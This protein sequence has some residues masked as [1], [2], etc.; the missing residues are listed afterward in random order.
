MKK[1]FSLTLGL[2][3]TICWANAQTVSQ[4]IEFKTGRAA[5]NFAEKKMK[6][7]PKKLYINRFNVNFQLIYIDSE[8]TREGVYHGATSST[9][10]VGFE[11]VPQAD[12]QAITDE[13]Y[14]NYITK[15]EAAGYEILTADDASGIKEFEEYTR[16][17]GGKMSEVQKLGYGTITPT[18]FDYYVKRLGKDG[19]EKGIDKSHKVSQQL[20]AVVVNVDLDVPFMVESESGASKLATGIVGGVSK[21]VASPYLRVDQSSNIKYHF[22]AQSYLNIPLKKNINISG[23]FKD[24]KFKAVAGAEAN[25]SYSMGYHTIVVSN[26]VDAKTVQV[27]ECDANKYIAGVKEAATLYLDKSTDSFLGYAAG[28]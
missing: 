8:Q 6:K 27:A 3:L 5:G 23:V 17:S 15:M 22:E 20:G 11:G 25:S 21:V 26:D 2:L 12:L 1:I 9:L 14:S 19:K 13:L 7:A 28:K 10:T 4:E 16:M 24:E 18:G